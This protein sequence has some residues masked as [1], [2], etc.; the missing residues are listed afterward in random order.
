MQQPQSNKRAVFK[1]HDVEFFENKTVTT[2][3]ILLTLGNY[4][5]K[6][7][8]RLWPN[9]ITCLIGSAA[10]CQCN[11]KSSSSDILLV[12]WKK[13]ST[14]SWLQITGESC[15]QLERCFTC[16]SNGLCAYLIAEFRLRYN[17]LNKDQI[18]VI[19]PVMVISNG[20]KDEIRPL[21]K[22]I[23]LECA[24]FLLTDL[25]IILALIKVN[26]RFS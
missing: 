5:K 20:I 25:L 22:S 7:R 17:A 8:L 9:V 18:V 23:N 15:S 2:S 6:H 21:N 19:G 1:D 16:P 4:K 13:P 10:K 3:Y 11:Y 24:V 14:L 12:K 26:I